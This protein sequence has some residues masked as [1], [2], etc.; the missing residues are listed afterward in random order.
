[1]GEYNNHLNDTV[2]GGGVLERR[3]DWGGT[4]DECI[5]TLFGAANGAMEN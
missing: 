2:G 1:M 3:H 5:F 4:C